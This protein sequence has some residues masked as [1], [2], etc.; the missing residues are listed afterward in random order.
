MK[1][2]LL[3]LSLIL[4][5]T[6][7]KGQGEFSLMAQDSIEIN[8]L[9]LDNVSLSPLFDSICDYWESSALSNTYS[10]AI[11]TTHLKAD[12]QLVWRVWIKQLYDYDSFYL[13]FMERPSF[14]RDFVPYG[15]LQHL[16]H[17]FFIGP[18]KNFSENSAMPYS[19]SIIEKSFAKDSNIIR[20]DRESIEKKIEVSDYIHRTDTVGGGWH[21]EMS[22]HDK[23][24]AV[25]L[26]YTKSA[27]GFQCL[28]KESFTEPW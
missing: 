22:V 12:T 28:K 16:H 17:L 3:L 18:E 14:T 26:E 25:L 5:V 19:Q 11:V 10:Y 7:L 6:F 23:Y 27:K 8:E 21:W 24:D 20:F 2:L 9:H 4:S 1:R 13:M 15:I